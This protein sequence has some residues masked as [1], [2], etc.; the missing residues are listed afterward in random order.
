M[1][2]D[3]LISG[4]AAEQESQRSDKSREGRDGTE[5]T[6]ESAGARDACSHSLAHCWCSV[7][8]PEP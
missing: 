5:D 7:G 3:D 4:T 6:T 8:S 2:E 1:R